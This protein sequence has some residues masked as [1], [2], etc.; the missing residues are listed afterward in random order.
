VGAGKPIFTRT[1]AELLIGKVCFPGVLYVYW[2]LEAVLVEKSVLI[3]ED[4]AINALY[5]S[6]QLK[7]MGYTVCA[8]AAS[9]PKAVEAA[10]TH[11]PWLILSDVRLA[12]DQTG[13]EAMKEIQQSFHCHVIIMSGYD[14]KEF[15][16][17]IFPLKPLAFL[18]KPVNLSMLEDY[19]RKVS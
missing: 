11:K 10:L 16:T 4:E 13:I 14:L 12:G 19:L 8:T 7:N 2:S 5:L 6:I 18:K 17:E 15:E 1:K 3:V 9:G